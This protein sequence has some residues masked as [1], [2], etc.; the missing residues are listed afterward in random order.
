MFSF[1]Q[2]LLC[3]LYTVYC[4]PLFL[5]EIVL[6]DLDCTLYSLYSTDCT[7]DN[8]RCNF[9]LFLIVNYLYFT[10]PRCLNV[11]ALYCTDTRSENFI[12][13]FL[14]QRNWKLLNHKSFYRLFE[15]FH[16]F[17][18]LKFYHFTEN[19]WQTNCTVFLYQF[20]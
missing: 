5:Y 20:F 10:L 17:Q 16:C 1:S 2:C 11:C 14:K 15:K 12:L 8:L 6:V 19:D 7:E 13:F 18:V 4:T 3:T 9:V